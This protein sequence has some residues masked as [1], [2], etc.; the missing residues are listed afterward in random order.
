MTAENNIFNK[1]E[2]RTKI[3]DAIKSKANFLIGYGS[4][5]G[6]NSILTIGLIMIISVSGF[7]LTELSLK[8]IIQKK[9]SIN[10]KN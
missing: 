4:A 1:P 2:L 3:F 8:K 10:N 6:R 9:S 5:T 7:E